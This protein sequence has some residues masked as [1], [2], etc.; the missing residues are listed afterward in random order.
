MKKVTMEE[1]TMIFNEISEM[2]EP[3]IMVNVSEAFMEAFHAFDYFW[4]DGDRMVVVNKR[5][6]QRILTVLEHALWQAVKGK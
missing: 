6:K 5:A 3:E 4:E 1:I 2:V